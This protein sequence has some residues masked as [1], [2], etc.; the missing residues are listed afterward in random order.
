MPCSM[1]LTYEGE[2]GAE[3]GKGGEASGP[4]DGAPP[5]RRGEVG[6]EES[7]DL[8]VEVGEVGCEVVVSPSSVS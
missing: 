3:C 8:V 4:S 2:F 1:L 5:S 6:G 7:G